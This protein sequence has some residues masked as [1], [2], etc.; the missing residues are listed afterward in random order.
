MVGTRLGSL[1]RLITAGAAAAAIAAIVTAAAS[2]AT[3]AAPLNTCPPTIEGTLVVDAACKGEHIG[4][5]PRGIDV[6]G[7]KRIAEDI[8]DEQGLSWCGP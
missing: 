1:G 8:A 4:R 2:G 7:A 5:E 3:Q 6:H